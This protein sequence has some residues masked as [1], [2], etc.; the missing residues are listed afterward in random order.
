M[1]DVGLRLAISRSP[2]G[3][4]ILLTHVYLGIFEPFLQIIVDSIVG[5]L[6]YQSK[7]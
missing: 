2:I 6:A 1:S 3:A 5:D 4:E 7:I